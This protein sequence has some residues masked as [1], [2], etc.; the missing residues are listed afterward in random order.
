MNSRKV[1]CGLLCLAGLYACKK[2]QVDPDGGPQSPLTGTTLQLTLDSI[3]LYALQTYLW[4][5][6]LPSYADFN[7]RKYAQAGSDLGNYKQAVFD[8]SQ[9]KKNPQTGIPYELPVFAGQPKYSFIQ[10]GNTYG[11]V[12]SGLSLESKGNDLGLGV[13][14]QGTAVYIRYVNPGSPAA[15]AGLQRGYRLTEING[16]PATAALA[17][18]MVN[19]QTAVIRYEKQDGSTGETTIQQAVYTSNSLYKSRIIDFDGTPVAYLALG[20]FNHVSGLKAGLDQAFASFVSARPENLIIDLRYNG[21]GYVESA[22]YLADLLAPSSLNQKVMYAKYFNNRL[23]QGK[24]GIL[25]KQLYFDN[26]GKAVYIKGRRATMAD[27][28]YSIT[29]NTSKF[30]KAGTLESIQHVYF[31]VSNNTASAS[32]LLINALKPYLQVKLVGS[33]TYG[34]PVGF[35]GLN[36]NAYTLY[37]SNFEV[38]NASGEGG[39]FDGMVPDQVIADDVSHDFGDPAE[40]CLATVLAMIKPGNQQFSNQK[41]MSKR[42]DVPADQHPVSAPVK[43][44]SGMITGQLKLKN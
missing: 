16:Q 25:N 41:A 3:Y 17:D 24:A 12:L 7:P 31:I 1:I 22:E 11:S 30:S 33:R 29:G 10:A 42:D 14:A 26:E 23:Q 27:V 40:Q 19:Q 9:L 28:D 20:Q 8:L 36:V 6:D 43:H 38:R 32:E 37:L 35:I 39:Y 44:F 5:E 21:G 4:N 2:T 13:A 15:T 34:K 18:Q